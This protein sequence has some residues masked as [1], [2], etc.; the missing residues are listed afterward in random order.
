MFLQHNAVGKALRRQSVKWGI[1]PDQRVTGPFRAAAIDVII[2]ID[3]VLDQRWSPVY[4][5]DPK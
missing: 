5:A 4:D 2:D 3:P 1:S